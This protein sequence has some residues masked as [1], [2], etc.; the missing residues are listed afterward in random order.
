MAGAWVRRTFNLFHCTLAAVIFY[1]GTITFWDALAAH[2]FGRLSPHAALVSGAE[3]IGAVL[4][5]IPNTLRVGGIILLIIF[6]IVITVHGLKAELPILV[7]AAG[8]IFILVHGS[9][10]SGKQ[11]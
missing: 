2:K 10:F 1:E 6:A 5:I 3:V 8:V 9:G 11:S 4:F 7:Y